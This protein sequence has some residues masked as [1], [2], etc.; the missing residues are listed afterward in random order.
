LEKAN[1]IMLARLLPHAPLLPE[2]QVMAFGDI[3]STQR[4]DSRSG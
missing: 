3:D 2:R 4:A 1:R